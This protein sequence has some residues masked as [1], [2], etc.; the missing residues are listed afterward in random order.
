MSY[1]LRKRGRFW[2]V[3]GSF[4]A[5]QTNGTIKRIRIEEST[6]TESLPRA[7]K[8]AADIEQHYHD[9]AYRPELK[10]GPTFSE[11]A[12]TYIRTR[13][14]SDR[15]ITKLIKHFRDT[16]I[17]DIDQA[18]LAETAQILY[19]RCAPATRLRAVFAPVAAIVRMSGMQ[20]NYTK[21]KVPKKQISIPSDEWFEA[22]IPHCPP[23]MAA[24]LLFLTLTG[25]RVSE[26]LAITEHDIDYERG[27]VLIP[28]TKTGDPIVAPLP[29]IVRDYLRAADSFVY[30]GNRPHGRLFGYSGLPSAHVAITRICKAAGVPRYGFHAIG[31]HSFATRGLKAGK[32]LKWVQQAGGW[33]TIKIVADR[34]AHLEQSP[35]HQDMLDLGQEWGSKLRL[36]KFS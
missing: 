15:F 22:V 33:K 12:L 28:N 35:I 10:R 34:Y 20:P 27:T 21:P 31:R 5:R 1:T 14:K 13:G 26:A 30:P 3:R 7:R 17:A 18:R 29:G 2:C 11:A 25:R 9:L 36:G 24:L 32:S 8:I 16:P 4:P 6:R 19:P 23:R